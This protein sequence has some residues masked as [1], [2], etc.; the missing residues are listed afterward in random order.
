METDRHMIVQGLRVAQLIPS[1]VIGHSRTGNNRGDTKVVNAPI[2]A[3]GRSKDATDKPGGTFV[4]RSKARMIAAGA[5]SF[6]GG[7]SA[8]LNLV[9]VSRVV[10]G[11]TAAFWV[12]AANAQ[13]VLP[14]T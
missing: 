8:Q 3:F 14:P 10:Q 12:P 13:R 9:P 1:I 2:N 4:E 5:L 6:P 11:T 7:R